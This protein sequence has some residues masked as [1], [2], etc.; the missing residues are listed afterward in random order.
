MKKGIHHK[1]FL[2]V[3][4]GKMHLI[5]HTH[6]QTHTHTDTQLHKYAHTQSHTHFDTLTVQKNTLTCDMHTHKLYTHTIY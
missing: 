5:T 4:M 2:V 1:T 3:R 6:T